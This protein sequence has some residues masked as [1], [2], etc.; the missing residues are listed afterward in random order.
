MPSSKSNSK[1]P[2]KDK[3]LIADLKSTAT[4]FLVMTVCISANIDFEMG[5]TF[6]RTGLGNRLGNSGF[7]H[8]QQ[9]LYL[10]KE[11]TGRVGVIYNQPGVGV[12]LKVAPSTRLSVDFFKNRSRIMAN[13]NQQFEVIYVI[14]YMSRY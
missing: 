7:Y 6:F 12:D 5:D 8:F 1:L 4:G 10:S 3:T 14:K 11:M 13:R 2:T 9:G